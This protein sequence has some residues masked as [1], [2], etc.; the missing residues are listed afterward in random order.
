MKSSVNPGQLLEEGSSWLRKGN[1]RSGCGSGSR[2]NGKME[3]PGD[4]GRVRE[5]ENIGACPCACMFISS[6]LQGSRPYE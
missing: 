6:S 4:P 3:D 5:V 2:V 1:L